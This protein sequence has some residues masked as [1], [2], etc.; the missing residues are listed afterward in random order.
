MEFLAYK[1][2]IY[3]SIYRHY[4]FVILILV[5]F[6]RLALKDKE[7]HCKK[8]NSLLNHMIHET[9]MRI[10]SFKGT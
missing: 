7:K 2:F 1:L 5:E 8:K 9:A 4:N 10:Y 6:I 3:I